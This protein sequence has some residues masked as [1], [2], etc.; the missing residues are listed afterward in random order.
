MTKNSRKLK[1]QYNDLNEEEIRESNLEKLKPLTYKELVDKNNPTFHQIFHDYRAKIKL[2]DEKSLE[3]LFSEWQSL[4]AYEEIIYSQ[5]T[6]WTLLDIKTRP[7]KKSLEKLIQQYAEQ[8]LLL[9]RQNMLIIDDM[10]QADLKENYSI[11]VKNKRISLP[12]LKPYKTP[13]TFTFHLDNAEEYNK[14][15]SFKLLTEIFKEPAYTVRKPFM[16]DSTPV[17]TVKM[18]MGK[19]TEFC[20]KIDNRKEKQQEEIKPE[21]DVWKE[22]LVD[23]IKKRT[24]GKKYTGSIFGFKKNTKLEAAQMLIDILSEREDSPTLFSKHKKLLLALQQ[25]DL[26]KIAEEPLNYIKNELKQQAKAAKNKNRGQK[27]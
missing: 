8:I 23:Y 15:E 13:L 5:V 27:T 21:L 3:A 9:T 6:L 11:Y 19:Y 2:K 1:N 18:T 4:I 14:T 16:R 26:K 7:V 24:T 22:K 25:G 12:N 10:L 20:D 17:I